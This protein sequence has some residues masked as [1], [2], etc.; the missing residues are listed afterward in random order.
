MDRGF[1]FADGVYEVIPVYNK[2]LFRLEQHLQRLQKSLAAI[3]LDFVIDIP[4]WQKTLT[5][6]LAHNESQG[7]N[8][9]IYL[10]I[11][12]GYSETRN[13]N[14]PEH[15][16]PTVFVQ[17]TP[18]VT[19]SIT[20]LS[21]GVNAI[22][23]PDTRWEFCYIKSIA[24]LANIL[25]THQA[26]QQNA[27]EAI[28]IRNGKA[29]EG[30]SSNLFIVK[31]N[32]LITPPLSTYILGGITR[33]LILELAKQHD[34]AYQEREILEEELFTADELWIASS[35]REIYPVINLNN[36][37]ISNGKSGPMWHKMIA[38]YR[39]HLTMRF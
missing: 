29:V 1:L 37:P 30:A 19:K 28:M 7:S 35:T 8:Q 36:K 39:S 38:L 26:K 13:H 27:N 2:Q 17:S 6:L 11:T 31:N 12:R 3:H 32:I 18:I 20:E 4:W 16:Q 21:H 34:L 22:T 23:L 25:A 33:E 9:A 14:F 24:L 5:T 10:Q 15:T